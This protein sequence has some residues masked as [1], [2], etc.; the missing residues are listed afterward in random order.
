MWRL[1]NRCWNW[2][3]SERGIFCANDVVKRDGEEGEKCMGKNL[4]LSWEKREIVNVE[5][6]M[7]MLER[8][9][10]GWNVWIRQSRC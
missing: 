2:W 8:E 4:R 6:R 7:G 1:K 5:F 3:R 10:N 9:K